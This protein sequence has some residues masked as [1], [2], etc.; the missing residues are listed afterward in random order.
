VQRMQ[1]VVRYHRVGVG[2]SRRKVPVA[3]GGWRWPALL[4]CAAVVIASLILPTSVVTYWLLRGLLAGESLLPL[5][6]ALLN[7]MRAAGLAA[8]SAALLALPVAY[9]IVRFPGRFSLAVFNL[10]YLG[11]GLPGIAIAL[12]LVFF[13]ANFAPFL[14]QTLAML[15]F[16]YIVR[17]L[18]EATGTLRAGLLQISPRLEE[19]AR[20]LG[21]NRRQAIRHIT[22]P[23]LQPGIWAGVALVFLSTIKELPATLLLGPTGFST[24]ATQIWSATSEAFYTRA[25]A[26]ALIL[27]VVSGLSIVLIL[28]QE[29]R[30]SS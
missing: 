10:S 6:A 27:L 7:S 23:L 12:S 18:P 9:L 13:G 17:F 20:T 11:N 21:L 25:A 8:M 26:P 5:W 3:L 24:L 29:E 28:Q 14:Y 30:N 2:A 19:A 1:G 16:A 22:I 15:I 4:L